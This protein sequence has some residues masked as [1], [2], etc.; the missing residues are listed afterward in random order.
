MPEETTR[1]PTIAVLG[2]G[3][4]G[5]AI[6]GDLAA[7]GAVVRGYDPAVPAPEHIVGAGGE[8]EAA[9]GA[10]LVLSVNSAHDAVGALR[11]GVAGVRAGAVWADL[12]TASPGLKRSL[13]G[14]ARAHGVRFA[15]VAI[16]APVPGRGLRTPM[17]ASGDGAAEV[18]AVLTPLGADVEVLPDGPGAAAARK[19][20]R[21]VFFKGLAAAVV[22]SLEAARSAGC[23][24]WL[25]DDI[26]A[27]LT[28][29]SAGTV[30]RLVT[31]THRHSV[32]RAAEM[33]AAADMLA[34]LG[35]P[36]LMASASRDLLERLSAEAAVRFDQ[37]DPGTLGD[38]SARSD[39]PG[40][41]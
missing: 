19:L 38:P 31:G 35:V 40:L 16:M 27:E 18:A 12:N 36:P 29:A 33:A 28:R 24:G 2:L 7:A 17:L 37:T 6:A 13:D 9:D 34:D 3:E 26:T 4:A 10:D 20:L 14:I 23:E 39:A 15:D 22:E 8:A 30:D 41:R 5:S 11:A 1:R 21:S 25:R 32:R